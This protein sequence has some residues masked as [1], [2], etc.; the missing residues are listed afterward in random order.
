[1]TLEGRVALVTGGGQGIGL[2]IG[3]AIVDRGG[4]VALFDV[5]AAALD[6]ARATF[7]A[8]ADVATYVVDVTERHGVARAVEKVEAELGPVYALFNNAGVI[9]SVSP[10][11]MRGDTWDFVVNVNL[12]GVYNGL[13][14][15]VPGMIARGE[16]GYIVNTSSL[17]G[18]VPAG[19][20]FAYHATKYAVVGLSESLRVELEHHNI[21]VSVVCPSQVA[22]DIVRNTRALR[23]SDAEAHTARVNGILDAAHDRLH[24]VGADPFEVGRNIVTGMLAG[25]PYLF[26]DGSWTELLEQRFDAILDALRTA[27]PNADSTFSL[28]ATQ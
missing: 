26:T 2:G 16:G 11:K 7:D 5:N 18:M 4:R 13:Q 28:G 19:S 27:Y 22:T 17:A 15:V 20:G 10:S 3:R 25:L 24:E 8:D 12:H 9:D 1:M 6:A 21:S 14:A 23:P